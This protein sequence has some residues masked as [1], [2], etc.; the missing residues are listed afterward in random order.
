MTF[1]RKA[2]VAV[3]LIGTVAIMA[4]VGW[5]VMFVLPSVVVQG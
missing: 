4:F 5:L 3:D 2:L 1:F